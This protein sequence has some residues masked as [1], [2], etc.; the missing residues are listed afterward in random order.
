MT[1]GLFYRPYVPLQMV[2]VGQDTFQPKIELKTRYGIVAN[3]FIEGN[4]S[5]QGLGRLLSTLTATTEESRL[6]TLCDSDITIFTESERVSFCAYIVS[7]ILCEIMTQ[8]N[9]KWKWISIGTVGSLFAVSHIGMIGMLSQR[10]S[11][12]PQINLPVGDYTSYR[13]DVSE[14]GYR[15]D[16]KGNDPTVM[17]VERDRNVKGGFLGLGNNKIRTVEEYTMDGS[18]PQGGFTSNPRS[19]KTTPTEEE[20]VGKAYCPTSRVYLTWV[21]GG[22]QTSR[23]VGTSIGTA[24]AP[25]VV[26]IPFVGWHFCCWLDRDVRRKPGHGNRW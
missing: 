9:S 2:R 11:K 26:N 5:N 24:A 7:T 12:L 19:C 6:Q 20:R 18:S 14:D 16:Y 4:V 1:A 17:R 10:G 23:V 3:P 21:G 25:A 8:P 22:K 15:I 13:A